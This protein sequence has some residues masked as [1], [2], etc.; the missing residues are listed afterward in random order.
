MAVSCNGEI[1]HRPVV[2][3]KTAGIPLCLNHRITA[4]GKQTQPQFALPISVLQIREAGRVR[5][6]LVGCGAAGGTMQ[7]KVLQLTGNLVV[8]PIN[9]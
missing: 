1:T 6:G 3:I 4:F 2:K 8:R 9:F 5:H 7:H